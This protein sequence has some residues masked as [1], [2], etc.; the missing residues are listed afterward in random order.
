MTDR[1]DDQR[2]A[3]FGGL[4]STIS[5][6]GLRPLTEAQSSRSVGW[7]AA[8]HA[9]SSTIV[10]VGDEAPLEEGGKCLLRRYG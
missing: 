4:R 3:G 2:G 7:V 6:P 1:G 10:L 9:S 8:S 5:P